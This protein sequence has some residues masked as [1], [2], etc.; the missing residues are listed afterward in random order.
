MAQLIYLA[1]MSLDGYM[2]D[3]NGNFDWAAPDDEVHHF[4]NDLVRPADTYLYGRRMYETMSVWE[5]D[6]DLGND[7]PATREF[8]AMWQAATKIVYSRTLK[9]TSTKRTVIRHEFDAGLIRQLKSG[10]SGDIGIGGAAI[11][12]EAFRARCVDAC[13]LFIAP[14]VV[15]GGKHCLPSDVPLSLALLTTRR[16]GNGM[17]HLHYS[18]QQT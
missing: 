4:I 1:I 13:H 8:A 3:T 10:A 6:A 14:T 11:A 7:S 5:T 9:T 16:F 2:E 12:A 15:G 17:V 18:V